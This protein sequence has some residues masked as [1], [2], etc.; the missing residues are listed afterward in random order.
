MRSTLPPVDTGRSLP[1]KKT[2]QGRTRVLHMNYT[3][4]RANETVETEQAYLRFFAQTAQKLGVCL[5]ILTGLQSVEDVK[6]ELSKDTYSGLDYRLA[7][8]PTPV[9]KW[10]EDSVEYLANGRMAVLTPFHDGLLAWAMVEGRR[11]RWQSLVVPEILADIL[12]H[13]D[14]WIPLGI[15][16]NSSQTGQARSRITQAQGQSVGHIRAYVEGGNMIT[17]E[18]QT[19]QP[20]ILVGKDAIATTGSL[21]Q[22][23]EPEVKQIIQE[24]FGLDTPEQVI[25]VEQPGQFHLDMGLLFIGNGVV[26]INDSRAALQDAQEMAE[27]APCE[28][29]RV[30]AAKRQLQCQLEAIATQD[31]T[32]ARLEVIPKALANDVMYNFFNGEFVEGGDRCQYYITNGGPKPQEETFTQ[33]MVQEWRVVNQVLFS[34]QSIAHKSLQE[35]GGVGCRLKGSPWT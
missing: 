8:S 18:D 25:S 10:A 5:E 21:Y 6:A 14:Q 26:V 23:T 30:M 34:P 7:V 29:T 16:V 27:L 19:G 13:D 20:I 2:P 1:Q 35:R 28:T 33:L 3:R 17:G 12:E 4:N 15:R 11:R 9:S 31:L 32:A 22:L 24:D